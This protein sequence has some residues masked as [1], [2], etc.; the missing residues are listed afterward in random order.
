MD[1]EGEVD[2]SE[3]GSDDD[4]DVEESVDLLEGLEMDDPPDD[5]SLSAEET[6]P[7]TQAASSVAAQAKAAVEMGEVWLVPAGQLAGAKRRDVFLKHLRAAGVKVSCS[8][9]LGR[10]GVAV[11]DLGMTVDDLVKAAGKQGKGLEPR[12]QPP[13]PAVGVTEST[14]WKDVLQRLQDEPPLFDLTNIWGLKRERPKTP[15]PQPEAAAEEGGAGKKRRKGFACQVGHDPQDHPNLNEH[16]TRWFEQLYSA[17]VYTNETHRTNGFA[18][19]IKILRDLEFPVRTPDDVKKLR[20]RPGI[21][22]GAVSRILHILEHNTLPLPQGPGEEDMRLILKTLN[23][24]TKIFGVGFVTARKLYEKGYRSLEDLHLRGRKDLSRQQNIGLDH[25]RDFELKIPRAEVTLIHARVQEVAERLL[26]GA[27]VTVCGSYRRGKPMCGD[28]DIL[29]APT[30]QQE[31]APKDTLMEIVQVLAAEK[32]LT[33]HLSLPGEDHK[34]QKK[35]SKRAFDKMN[36]ITVSKDTYMGVCRVSEQHLHRRIDIKIYP[37]SQLP[38]ALLYFTGSQYFNLSMRSYAIRMKQVSR[39]THVNGMTRVLVNDH[40]A[41]VI[42]HVCQLQMSLSDT[43]LRKGVWEQGKLQHTIGP[44]V[45]CEDEQA[46][47]AAL[48]LEYKTPSE[49]DCG[50]VER[51]VA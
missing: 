4:E 1:E 27:S 29:I 44:S 17:S 30:R 40:G 21:G 9:H 11:M 25:W 38:F 6:A 10:T 45:E 28:V 8:F 12:K 43:G 15:T 3:E 36:N 47:F 37:A 50:V 46:V 48:G 41:W 22:K 7:K 13:L 14:K 23:D 31:H 2:N 49:R 16:L 18:R 39:D 35:D 51:G 42:L 26:P 32:F 34:F 5:E 24:F 20:A 33:G 19:V